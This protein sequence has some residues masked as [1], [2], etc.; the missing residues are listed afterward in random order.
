MFVR[1]HDGSKVFV[2]VRFSPKRNKFFAVKWTISTHTCLSCVCVDGQWVI[3]SCGSAIG[4][5][6]SLLGWSRFVFLIERFCDESLQKGYYVSDTNRVT[7]NQRKALTKRTV[8]DVISTLVT[9]SVY[10]ESDPPL[11]IGHQE[12]RPRRF[13]VRSWSLLYTVHLLMLLGRRT[14]QRAIQKRNLCLLWPICHQNNAKSEH[15]SPA[16]L[17][18]AQPARH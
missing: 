9:F 14:V 16:R 15:P 10:C 17:R 1:L 18:A 13:K 2:T 7:L 4:K 6:R 3:S 8:K 11:Q 5:R 12:A